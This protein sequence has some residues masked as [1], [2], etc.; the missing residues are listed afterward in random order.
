[1]RGVFI[2]FFA[3]VLAKDRQK[4]ERENPV[5]D[6]PF[7]NPACGLTGT[8][9]PDYL[10]GVLAALLPGIRRPIKHFIRLDRIEDSVIK[11]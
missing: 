10:V 6:D 2:S 7:Y 9:R 8:I 5:E 3:E 11:I 4:I 1:M